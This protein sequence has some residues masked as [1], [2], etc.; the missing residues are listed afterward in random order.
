MQASELA[1][2]LGVRLAGVGLLAEEVVDLGEEL[3]G[4]AVVGDGLLGGGLD[5]DGDVAVGVEVVLVA[6]HLAGELTLLAGVPLGRD[7]QLEPV[8]AVGDEVR[9]RLGLPE[10]VGCERNR[11]HPR[12]S[13]ANRSISSQ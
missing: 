2:N 9:V 3:L 4:R 13:V 5:H 7:Q 12:V 6:E 1:T 10:H 8:A 11:L